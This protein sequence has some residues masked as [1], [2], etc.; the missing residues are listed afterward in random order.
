MSENEGDR[1]RPQCFN[2]N[3]AKGFDSVN[4]MVAVPGR[5]GRSPRHFCE[6][7]AER[8]QRGPPMTDGGRFS[9]GTERKV[10]WYN[11]EC[12]SENCNK[13]MGDMSRRVYCSDCLDRRLESGADRFEGGARQ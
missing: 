7:C 13:T 1:L 6:G 2:P 5:G 9:D 4:D 12:R 10:E 3:C 8:I 11:R